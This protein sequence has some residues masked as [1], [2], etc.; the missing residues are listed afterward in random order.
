[1]LRGDYDGQTGGRGWILHKDAGVSGSVEAAI[2]VGV[3]VAVVVAGVCRRVTGA[4][5]R[6]AGQRERDEK[7]RD[8]KRRLSHV[9]APRREISV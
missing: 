9:G 3:G 7:Q 6:A 8:G 1:M 4:L 5:V 2:A